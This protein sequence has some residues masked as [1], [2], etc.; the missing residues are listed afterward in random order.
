ML[1]QSSKIGLFLETSIR[2]KRFDAALLC[3]E[4]KRLDITCPQQVRMGRKEDGGW[5]VCVT[6]PYNIV[7][8]C[9]I[10]SFG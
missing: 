9:L 5:D 8:P 2:R 3:S 6:G 10:Y 7:E 1:Q 4:S